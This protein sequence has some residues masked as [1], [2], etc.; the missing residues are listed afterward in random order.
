MSPQSTMNLSRSS[1]GQLG[2][3]CEGLG[4]SFGVSPTLL[5]LIWLI[6]VFLGGTGIALYF[7]LWWLL[8]VEN[9]INYEPTIWKS[10]PDGNHRP[11]LERTQYNRKI[12]GI[13][14]GLARRWDIDPTLIR[15]LGIS[16]AIMSL[17]VGI[18]IYLIAAII[19]PN[20]SNNLSSYDQI[21]E[22]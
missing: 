16:L 5:R 3:V 1:F 10:G 13:C 17:G 12:L 8:P 18:I 6:A 14:G 11:P 7:L 21:I 22:L 4:T 2:G 9:E 19:V 20:A 15:L